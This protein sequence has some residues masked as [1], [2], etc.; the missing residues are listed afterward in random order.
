MSHKNS[1][2]TYFASSFKWK[3]GKPR[4][5]QPK[6]VFFFLGLGKLW[7]CV[8][9]KYTRSQPTPPGV[10][11]KLLGSTTPPRNGTH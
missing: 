7:A 10:A 5:E 1:D 3:S 4:R 9:H 2:Q 6:Y 11:A 8:L